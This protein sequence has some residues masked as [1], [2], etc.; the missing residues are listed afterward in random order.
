M[1]ARL[2]LALLLTAL[3]GSGAAAAAAPAKPSRVVVI[4][5]ENRELDE[6]IGDPEAA[7][8]NYLAGRGALAVNYYAVAHPSLPNY[9]AMLGGDTFG[10]AE[11]CTECLVSGPNLATQLSRAGVSWKAYMSGLPYPCYTG[12]DVGRYAKRHNPFV[13]FPW[14]TSAPRRCAR[15]VPEA[16]LWADLEAHR[17]PSFSWLTPDL[18]HDAHDCLFSAADH[19]LSLL[20]P[21]IMR[22]L[23]PH[24]LL[25]VTFDEGVGDSGGGGWI[26]TVLA[27]PDVP[28][29]IQ[30][31]RVVNHYSLLAALEDRFGLPRLRFARF[32]PPL[33]P[34]LFRAT[35]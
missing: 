27:G 31:R 23:G 16:E 26:A 22:Q 25:V 30:I 5:L 19:Y 34:A 35:D 28:R 9:L 13:Y 8:V 11:N 32:A 1:A 2:C 24:G 21:R 4:V 6:V 15:V 14:L 29:G 17:L 3:L 33:A 12:G 20:A 18:C 7:F 10:I